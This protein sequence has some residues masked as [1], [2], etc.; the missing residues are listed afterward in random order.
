M[1]DA[2]LLGFCFGARAS[3]E[4]VV[5]AVHPRAAA[6][7]LG[8]QLLRR[9]ADDLAELA[10]WLGQWAT[11]RAPCKAAQKPTAFRVQRK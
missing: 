5:L 10:A 2:E 1:S 4:I 8:R 3:G 6:Q 9:L 11:S 7:G